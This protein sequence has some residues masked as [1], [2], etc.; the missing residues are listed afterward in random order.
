[1]VVMLTGQLNYITINKK[2][3]FKCES[4]KAEVNY[5][6]FKQLSLN[7]NVIKEISVHLEED[8]ESYEVFLIDGLGRSI[9]YPFFEDQELK[10]RIMRRIELYNN[11][12]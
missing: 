5:S 6:N 7:P 8:D 3:G 9:V 10:T 2:N 12:F 11:E 1:M 4:C